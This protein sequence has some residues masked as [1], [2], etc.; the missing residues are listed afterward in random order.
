MFSEPPNNLQIRKSDDDS[1]RSQTITGT[2]GKELSLECVSYGGN[3][4]PKLVWIVKGAVV[5]TKD[6]QDESREVRRK[7]RSVFPKHIFTIG[8]PIFFYNFH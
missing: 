2:S 4:A 6:A 3:P 7:W 1:P 8:F 5:E